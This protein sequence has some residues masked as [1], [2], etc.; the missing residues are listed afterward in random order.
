MV[1]YC[2]VVK[3][4]ANDYSRKGLDL[5]TEFVKTY[6]ASGL[7]YLNIAEEVTGSIAKVITEEDLSN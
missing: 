6:R 1:F 4:K 7:A 2:L 5:L 3:D